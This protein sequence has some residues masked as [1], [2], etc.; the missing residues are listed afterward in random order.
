MTGVKQI[1]VE[2]EVRVVPV[3][4]L[5]QERR[6]NEAIG[7]RA[8][9]LFEARGCASWHELDDWRRAESQVRCKMCFGLTEG[10]NR[11]LIGC[12]LNRFEEGTVEI[13]VAPRRITICGK[14]LERVAISPAPC[15]D[16]KGPVFREIELKTEINPEEVAV[17]RK[18]RLLEIKLP[19]SHPEEKLLKRVQAA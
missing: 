13:W 6:V 16:Y 11:I 2:H 12:D 8:Y 5:E 15:A 4:A 14:P 9:E 1:R 3:G 7:R 19:F 10:E 17:D 18:H